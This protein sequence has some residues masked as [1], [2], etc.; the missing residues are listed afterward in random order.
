MNFYERAIERAIEECKNCYSSKI[1][2]YKSITNA[3]LEHKIKSLK[4]DLG[5]QD[6]VECVGAIDDK[7]QLLE[8][9]LDNCSKCD[10]KEALVANTLK[11]LVQE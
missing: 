5:E 1:Q 3:V 7:I 9:A 4:R 10:K 2:I 8:E 11:I 6:D